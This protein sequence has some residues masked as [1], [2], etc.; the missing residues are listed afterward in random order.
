MSHS[1]ALEKNHSC[2][3]ITNA[4][5][6]GVSLNLL[7][8]WNWFRLDLSSQLHLVELLW[9]YNMG[10]GSCL[11]YVFMPTS[12]QLQEDW[13]N[14]CNSQWQSWSNTN[15]ACQTL[16]PRFFFWRLLILSEWVFIDSLLSAKG[17]RVFFSLSFGPKTVLALTQNS[18]LRP[19]CYLI[20]V[21]VFNDKPLDKSSDFSDTNTVKLKHT[22]KS[23]KGDWRR[24][25]EYPDCK[26]R[27]GL[28]WHSNLISLS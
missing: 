9:A 22:H 26:K 11:F 27:A 14:W 21:N 28:P 13:L 6:I 1:E 8:A 25:W 19:E 3:S 20:K 23:S 17:L 2:G 5:S 7:T 24:L 18:S 16:P 4:I 12:C 15:L 10:W